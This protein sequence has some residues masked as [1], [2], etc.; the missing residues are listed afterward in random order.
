M[1]H[2][3]SLVSI[4]SSTSAQMHWITRRTTQK[5]QV[6]SLGL[7]R[8]DEI[9]LDDSFQSLIC[10][11]LVSFLFFSF[12][13]FF[14][15]AR[16]W[17]GS[18]VH[19]EDSQGLSH[20]SY[21]CSLQPTSARAGERGLQAGQAENGGHLRHF[22]RLTNSNDTAGIGFMDNISLMDCSWSFPPQQVLLRFS[23]K[24]QR[25]WGLICAALHHCGHL[26]YFKFCSFFH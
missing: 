4:L 12:F 24:P 2:T 26:R 16:S 20:D 8:L 23:M 9:V 3:S 21:R 5:Q 22:T 13:P 15:R 19:P 10:T 1:F 18:A 14:L 17:K 6:G 7:S 11:T 25:V